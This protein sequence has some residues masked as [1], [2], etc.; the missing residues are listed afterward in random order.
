MEKSKVRRMG[1]EKLLTNIIS[2]V[3]FSIGNV[4]VLE[5]FSSI[6]DARFDVWMEQQESAGKEFT[7]EQVEWLRMIK[8]HI[9]TSLSISTEDFEYS[10]FHDKG[11]PVKVYELFG[12]EIEGILEDLSEVLAA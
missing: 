1:P 2:L 3:R 10:P 7:P 4:E 8:N 11:G 6:V 5:P 9:A 12:V